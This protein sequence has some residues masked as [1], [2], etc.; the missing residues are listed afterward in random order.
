MPDET[1]S[2]DEKNTKSIPYPVPRGRRARRKVEKGLR[3]GDAG[4]NRPVGLSMDDGLQKPQ[5]R[6]TLRAFAKAD[7]KGD[8][9]LGMADGVHSPSGSVQRHH[10]Y[11][12]TGVETGT[13]GVPSASVQR[14]GEYDGIAAE[15]HPDFP[16]D[17]QDLYEEVLPG[18]VFVNSNT[19]RQLTPGALTSAPRVPSVARQHN[20]I[21]I[22]E[23]SPPTVSVDEPSSPDVDQLQKKKKRKRLLVI[24][25]LAL[26]VVIVVAVGTVVAT[27]TRSSGDDEEESSAPTISPTM[28]ICPE[29]SID[30]KEV[31]RRCEENDSILEAIPPCVVPFYE[32]ALSQVTKPFEFTESCTP[33]TLS[34]SALA[35]AIKKQF[36]SGIQNPD[37]FFNL[38]FLHF[39]LDGP[40]SWTQSGDWLSFQI[41]PCN[42]SGVQCNEQAVNV[43]LSS[44][45]NVGGT[46]P[47]EI[48]YFSSLGQLSISGGTMGGTFPPELCNLP[49]I[50][51]IE[52]IN[53][54]LSG[55]LPSDLENC[56][57][58][59]SL[60]INDVP[61]EG[62][63]PSEIGLLKEM[64]FLDIGFSSLSGTIPQEILDLPNL[65]R[66]GI[67]G[68][69]SGP[70]PWL[71]SSSINELYLSQTK[72]TGVIPTEIG[73]KI[74]LSTLLIEASNLS[75]TIPSEIGLLSSLQLLSISGSRGIEG[76]LPTEMGALTALKFLTLSDTSL[77]GQ[78]PT[79]LAQCTGLERIDFTNARFTGTIPAELCFWTR[80]GGV[81]FIY[82]CL[83]STCLRNEC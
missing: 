32:T 47:S 52:I 12:I 75:S 31:L 41:D 81:S 10:S 37:L 61:M 72:I 16:I 26:I 58:L 13:V 57:S 14:H 30:W 8:A 44:G 60:S 78:L 43:G 77:V 66:F 82:E 7:K 55:T 73:T 59:I 53:N 6:T 18:A 35:F 70:F 51:H 64:R 29:R 42:W 46:L 2:N 69:I 23:R 48:G 40:R 39:S 71:L 54:L 76:T 27:T 33:S 63:I 15:N 19:E 65:L 80:G 68:G 36:L 28:R 79:E 67:R 20:P 74:G 5:V 38:A 49:N 25:V 22:P 50:V 3:T 17:T 11:G 21:L 1:T 4:E 56:K 62:T 24:L 83:F 34:L 45:K 9:P